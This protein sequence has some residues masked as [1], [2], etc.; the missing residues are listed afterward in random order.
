MTE[1]KSRLL[2]VPRECHGQR[3]DSVLA[4]LIPEFS[5]SQLSSWL[6][7]GK[8]TINKQVLKPKD[9]V[10]GGEEIDF[11][12]NLSSLENKVEHCEA[13]DIPL[14]IIYEDEHVL[15]INKPSG[16]IVHPGAGNPD[17]TLVNALLY[18]EPS[19]QHLPRAGIIHRLD[20]ETTGLLV[21]A[22]TLTSQTNLVRQMQERQIQ[23][24]Y[25][26]LVQGHV[27]SGGEIDTN[28]GRHPR[29]RLKMAVCAHGRQATTL[30]S[31]KKQ[32]HY[33]TLLDVQLLTGR[34]HQIR[35]HMAHINHPVIGDPL[36]GGRMRY[37]A[38]VCEELLM[39]LQQFKRQALHAI[40]LSFVHPA[41]EK[42]LTFTAPLP[43]DFQLLINSL[44]IYLG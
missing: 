22:K 40:S 38:E 3:I 39:V 9:K 20:K 29:N 10:A 15:V 16:L 26:T 8:I 42:L 25:L 32:Y 18:H 27:I 35:V 36:Y 30:Y 13:Q 19:L 24:R 17:N 11:A 23:R 12:V 6:K 31:L 28:Y 37:P 41:T 43:D 2:L 34:T 7:E 4:G 1:T 44:D 5:R 21:V 14:N 33:Y